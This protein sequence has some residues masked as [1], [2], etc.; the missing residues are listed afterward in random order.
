MR[1]YYARD[2]AP[3]WCKANHL[4]N[5]GQRTLS[6]AR[7]EIPILQAEATDTLVTRQVV[8]DPV[9]SPRV[10]SPTT[11]VSI[12]ETPWDP[13]LV[14]AWQLR[15]WHAM[16]APRSYA[17]MQERWPKIWFIG[18]LDELRAWLAANDLHRLDVGFGHRVDPNDAAAQRVYAAHKLRPLL[19]IA[20]EPSAATVWS[21]VRAKHAHP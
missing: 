13:T 2:E 7:A 17:G 1:A 3:C 10:A 4:Q 15:A 9:E 5:R 8:E 20:T 16:G 14:R 19:P 12:E 11:K 6:V 21:V 18:S